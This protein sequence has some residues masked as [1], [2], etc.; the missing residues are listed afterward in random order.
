MVRRLV[1]SL[2][3]VVAL[4]SVGCGAS[5]TKGPVLNAGSEAST[6]PP[7]VADD[8]TWMTLAAQGARMKIP[9]GWSWSR[10]GDAFVARPD[11]GKAAIVFAG[12]TTK[13][14]LETEVRSIG[15]SYRLD[16][17][18][19]RKNGRKA[20]LHGIDVAVFEDMAAETSGTPTDVLVL[21][22]DAPNGRGVV[23]VFIMA[24]D[25]SQSHDLAIIDAANSLRPL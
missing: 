10:K 24:W 1:G 18:D 16:E 9:S 25:A 7:G 20:K 11:D 2:V 3:V 4:A 13:A 5:A 17:V 6:T 22:A 15:E 19:F 12:A 14:A 8:A 23:V 21:L